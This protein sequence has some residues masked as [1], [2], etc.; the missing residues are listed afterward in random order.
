MA[1]ADR[2]ES[3]KARRK[4]KAAEAAASSGVAGARAAAAADQKTLW[5]NARAQKRAFSEAWL[6]LLT[7]PIPADIYRKVSVW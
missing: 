6:A 2:G 4:R 1:S 5:A 7:L 3:A